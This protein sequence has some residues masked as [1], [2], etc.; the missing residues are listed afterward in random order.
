MLCPKCR[1]EIS[2]GSKFCNHCGAALPEPEPRHA[3]QDSEGELYSYSDK[4]KHDD[5]NDL[6][7]DEPTRV[8]DPVRDGVDETKVYPLGAFTDGTPE[9]PYPNDREDFGDSYEDYRD[10]EDDKTFMDK[11]DDRFRRDDEY[12]DRPPRKSS[13]TWLWI[14][15]GVLAA[16]L[17]ILFAILTFSGK[18][19]GGKNNISPTVKPTAAAAVQP[20]Q[21]P[22]EAPVPTETQAPTKS[23][24]TEPP[25]TDAP[26]TDAPPITEA[27]RPT[28]APAP[29]EA[30]APTDPPVETEE[31]IVEP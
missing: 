3:R 28:D 12:D 16:V 9:P 15:L 20:T 11:L 24:E 2:E 17:I 27:P 13:K 26:A 23:P 6:T 29:T 21:T 8:F 22:T 14:T 4:G 10:D 25:A 5:L 19:F 18:L 31:Q 7:P 1:K 30:P